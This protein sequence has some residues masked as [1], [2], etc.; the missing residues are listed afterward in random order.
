MEEPIHRG[1]QFH[2]E[3]RLEAVDQRRCRVERRLIT[4]GFSRLEECSDRLALL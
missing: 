4:R 3:R 2:A 1:E